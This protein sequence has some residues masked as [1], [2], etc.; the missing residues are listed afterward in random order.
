MYIKMT[1][2]TTLLDLIAFCTGRTLLPGSNCFLNEIA[3]MACGNPCVRHG[4][5]A[6]AST[7]VLD[8][9]PSKSLEQRANMHYNRSVLL[10][11][12]ALSSRETFEP[13]KE[14]VVIA[15]LV[16]LSVNDLV[17]WEGNQTSMNI[18]EWLTGNRTAKRVLDLSDPGYK[19][20]HPEN[21]QYSNVRRYMGGKAALVDIFCSV[22]APLETIPKECPYSWLLEGT[23]REIR[24]IDGLNG[25]SPKLLH[26]YAQVT[27]LSSRLAAR[28]ES[29]VIPQ[30][31]KV[32]EEKLTNFWQWSEFSEGYGTPEDLLA[33]CTLDDTGKVSNARKVTEL[34]AE[35][36]V[37]SA[38]IYLQCRLFRKP[39]A[40]LTVQ[41]LAN[42]LLDC[43]VRMPTSGHTFTAMAP[44]F[45]I[46]VTGL[47]VYRSAD[48]DIIRDWFVGVIKGTRGNVPPAWKALQTVWLWQDDVLEREERADLEFQ[49]Q[50]IMV[51]DALATQRRDWWKEMV[52]EIERSVGKMNLA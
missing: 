51:D 25:L 10:L 9:L 6:L 52:T 33:S 4:L 12:Q 31:G 22:M 45:S 2:L 1:V 44:M 23:E 5:L 29:S 28:P 36:Y 32:I 7:Y 3:A 27:H 11:S 38:E 20:Q 41:K 37:T 40:H 14:D 8:Y 35:C 42:R 17:N 34:T 24:K 16:L 47:V 43:I 13:G 18:P 46:F 50:E 19:F 39:R 30:A 21:V 15:T 49:Q 48:R 26:M